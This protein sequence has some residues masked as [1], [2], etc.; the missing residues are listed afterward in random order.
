MTPL[1][2]GG[3][4]EHFSLPVR[5][6]QDKGLISCEFLAQPGGTGEMVTNLSNGTLDVAIALTEVGISKWR[7]G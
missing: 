3:V 2:L 5:L 7:V 1:R 6:A 4:P